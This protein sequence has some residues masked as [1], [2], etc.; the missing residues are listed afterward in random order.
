MT[1]S[2]S[3]SAISFISAPQ[4][5][6]MRGYG[7]NVTMH[8][9]A[10]QLDQADGAADGAPVLEERSSYRSWARV[11]S[12]EYKALRKSAKKGCRIVIHQYGATHPAECFAVS[13]ETFFE[14]PHQLKTKHPE[15]FE[16]LKTFYKTDPLTWEKL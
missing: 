7:Q 12:R 3:M 4:C 16:E 2:P 9:F 15:L 1:S 10:H 11:L 13:M 6:Q 5:W 14:K 8:E